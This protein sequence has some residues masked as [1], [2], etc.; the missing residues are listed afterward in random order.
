MGTPYGAM[1]ET[2]LNGMTPHGTPYATCTVHSEYRIKF[3]SLEKN[4]IF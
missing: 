1:T 2:S 3:P 4:T